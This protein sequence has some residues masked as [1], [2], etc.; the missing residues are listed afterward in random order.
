MK[1]FENWRAR[2]VLVMGG[3]S[4]CLLASTSIVSAQSTT[5]GLEEI[6]VT[7]QKREQSLQDVG[8]SVSAFTETEIN[9]MGWAN[10]EDIAFQTPGLIATSFSGGSSTGLFS[11]R[12]LSQNDFADH[13]EA[14]SAVYID[15]VYIALTGSATSE[16]F[17]VSRVEVLRGPQGTLF[18]R[19]ATGGVVHI[20]TNDPTEEFEGYADLT[21]SE[22]DHLRLEGAFGGPITDNVAFRVAF[23]RDISDG[24]FKNEGALKG[25][26][27][28]FVF[29]GFPVKPT[30]TPRGDFRD[31]DHLNIRGKLRF[32]PSDSLQI[33][34]SVAFAEVDMT[35]NA[36][37]TVPTPAGAIDTTTTDFFGTPYNPEKHAEAPNT[38][39]FV[40]KESISYTGEVRWFGDAFDIIA[41][42]NYS[43]N[44]KTYLEDD[45]GGPFNIAQF[46]TDQDADTYS[47]E[48]RFEG[49]EERLQW[50]IGAYY[51][52]IAGDYFGT[53][54][55]P[56]ITGA[57]GPGVFD[58]YGFGY[59]LDYDLETES[60]AFFAQGEY[61]IT[62]RL[63]AIIGSR[64]T[65][66]KKDF[67]IFAQCLDD[68][69]VAAGGCAA[70]GVAPGTLVAGGVPVS[71]DK[72]D[73]FFSWRAQL[74]FRPTDE[75]M[76]YAGYNRGVKA[77]SFSAPL[78][79]LQPVSLLPFKPEFLD[80]YEI[81][82]KTELLNQR[83]RLNVSAFYYDYKDYQA[84]VFKGLTTLV[85]NNNA[86]LYG[87]E[88]EVTAILMEGL[89]VRA[90]VAVLDAT[91]KDVEVAPGVFEDQNMILAPDFTANWMV[92]KSF[93]LSGDTNMFAQFD[94]YYSSAQ[95]FN[96]INSPL[97]KSSSYAI[98]NASLGYNFQVGGSD[99]QLQLF[100]KNITNSRP[101]N[102]SFDLS[103]FFGNTI[104]VFGPP[105]IF[106]GSLRFEY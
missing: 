7:A 3:I 63:R 26:T 41:I 64:W 95:Y 103:A 82:I 5:Y 80:D 87:G 72:S 12:G 59:D 68:P 57:S 17:D 51:L 79:G 76:L 2:S 78:D 47:G 31:R 35:G 71:L 14:P 15:G 36:Y 104:Q 96:T 81:G 4:A 25:T 46:G 40:D 90:G 105:R 66:D 49:Q 84:F 56:G 19:N 45:D 89:D 22:Y 30:E 39:G 92:R 69:Q 18:G 91:V 44:E 52:K 58:G 13:Q 61:D 28:P 50:T 77:G 85:T 20:V 98:M 86:E 24:Y 94:G 37:D 48:L 23:L 88:I 101:L 11:I 74:E 27:P 54:Q 1:R 106:G 29:G 73:D 83:L 38:P 55:F 102:Y 21:V 32:T 62:S 75:I 16:L 70:F 60:Y 8:I 9:Q 53:F 33:D 42:A 34:L 93:D 43:E 99:V 67:D 97:V 10:S 65:K 6:T 100:V